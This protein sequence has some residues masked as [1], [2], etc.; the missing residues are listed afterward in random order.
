MKPADSFCQA[1]GA[2]ASSKPLREVDVPNDLSPGS[3]TQDQGLGDELQL[4]ETGL[5]AV[6]L[7][8]AKGED[9]SI[10]HNLSSPTSECLNACPTDGLLTPLDISDTR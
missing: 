5:A 7:D 1:S 6:A 4:L 10:P 9:A 8:Q 3:R 2:R